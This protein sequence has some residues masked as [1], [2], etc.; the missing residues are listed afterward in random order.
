[1]RDADLHTA[2]VILILRP[3]LVVVRRA[4][5]RRRCLLLHALLL[6]LWL[7]HLV[8]SARHRLTI[9]TGHSP[10]TIRSSTA[11]SIPTS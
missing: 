2:E 8:R 3:H 10:R 4:V 1:M 6:M 11:C 9:E 5:L 7:L